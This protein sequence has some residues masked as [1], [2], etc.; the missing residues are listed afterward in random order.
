MT[1][2][3]LLSRINQLVFEAAREGYTQDEIMD[4]VESALDVVDAPDEEEDS[5]DAMALR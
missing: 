5:D 3:S 4:A 1:Q 2:P